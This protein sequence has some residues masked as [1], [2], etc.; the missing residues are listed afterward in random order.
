MM[1]LS[2]ASELANEGES[3]CKR[4]AL[5]FFFFLIIVGCM[6]VCALTWHGMHVGTRG[7]LSEIN[8]NASFVRSPFKH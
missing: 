6:F 8:R 4:R 3:K 5:K 2:P 7:S 1:E